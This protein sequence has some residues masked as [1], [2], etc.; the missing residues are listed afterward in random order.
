MKTPPVH[1]RPSP[2]G[3]AAALA[4]ALLPTACGGSGGERAQPGMEATPPPAPGRAADPGAA[5]RA[6][7]RETPTGADDGPERVLV[8]ECDGVSFTV[9]LAAAEAAEAEVLLPDR[10]VTL[11]RVP[12]ASG[13]RYEG[14]GMVFW[15]RGD[16]ARLELPEGGD[17]DC[18]RDRVAETFEA[19]RLEG[20]RFRAL[21]QEPGWVLDIFPAPPLLRL[22][23]DYGE[24]E[25]R[26]PTTAP[27]VDADAGTR[28][29]ETVTDAH[30]VRVEIADRACSDAM[31]GLAFPNTVTVTL[32]GR[33]LEGCGRPLGPAFVGAWS[34]VRFGQGADATGPV[35]STSPGLDID[36][37]GRVA[38]TTG[39]NG[40]SG[41][42][43]SDAPGR[44]SFGPLA[45]TKM[46][47]AEPRMTQETRFSR[48]LDATRGYR[49]AADT[50]RLVGAG[51]DTLASFHGGAAR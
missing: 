24:V 5:S 1:G 44:L 25:V 21:G 9:R 51:G 36:A 29:V 42:W 6:P 39:C 33:A 15:S 10:R 12:A 18:A 23:A 50:L 43:M 35:A 48:A 34:L 40:L 32:D 22:V 11:P 17:T 8:Y 46:A 41:E 2:R 30:R 13:T 28:T 37:W 49:L 3:L 26:G 7:G 38:V 14:E 47:C 19:A 16:E 31:S 45:G 27:R 4:A 20:A